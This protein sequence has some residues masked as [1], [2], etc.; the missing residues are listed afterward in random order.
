MHARSSL[1]GDLTCPSAQ[2]RCWASFKS[3]MRLWGSSLLRRFRFVCVDGLKDL[4]IL[5][6]LSSEIEMAR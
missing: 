3:L 2:E 1:R 4:T 5:G 6:Q